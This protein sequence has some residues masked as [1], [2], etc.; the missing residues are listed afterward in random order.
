MG[1][2]CVIVTFF[3]ISAWLY[4]VTN[5]YDSSFY[6]SGGIFVVTGFVMVPA[7]FHY[8]TKRASN[9]EVGN[10]INSDI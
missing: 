1:L 8:H 6:L 10:V 4:G 3:S 2:Y 7:V 9:N 5:V